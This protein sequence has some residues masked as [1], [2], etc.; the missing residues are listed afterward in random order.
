MAT[1]A[2]GVAGEGRGHAGRALSLI[3][4]LSRNHRVVVYTSGQ[5][6]TL[7]EPVL[8]ACGV[9]L[10]R[11]PEV[12]F[13]Y[14]RGQRVDYPRTLFQN[15]PLL[16]QLDPVSDAYARELARLGPD[17]VVT[18][19]EP[20]LPR[21]ADRVGV[22]YVSVD[23]QHFLVTSDLRHLPLPLQLHAA[24]MGRFVHAFYDTQQETIVSSFFRTQPSGKIPHVTQVGVMLRDDVVH[25]V[26]EDRGHLVAYLRREASAEVLRPLLA[27]R[28]PVVVYGLGARLPM[29]N[30]RFREIDAVR[31]VEDLATATALV[32]TAG[33]QLVGEALYL[34]K[35]VLAMSEPGNMEQRIHAHLLEE[36]GA[37]VGCG[38]ES[39]SVPILQ[40]FLEGLDVYRS[41]IDRAALHGN[42]VVLARLEAR[43]GGG[44]V[45]R[46]RPAASVG[47][48]PAARWSATRLVS[49]A[50]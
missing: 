30:L 37:G 10:R 42:P 13:A 2:Y 4:T 17:L 40:G 22:P 31:F 7:M 44:A 23:H 3:E 24:F 49:G 39:L 18:D 32:T 50:W 15:L 43:L 41:R 38:M 14:G 48:P 21:A 29:G 34:G 1:I 12:R 46:P 35:P 5:A 47:R 19:F 45:Q 28:H 33:N 11:A 20:I 16:R 8:R 36:M 25:A 27:C 6:R 9:E 26:P